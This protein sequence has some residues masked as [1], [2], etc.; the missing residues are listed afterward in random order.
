MITLFLVAGVFNKAS[1]GGVITPPAPDRSRLDQFEIRSA[2]RLRSWTEDVERFVA[3]TIEAERKD[4]RPKT[5]K[6][7]A[8]VVNDVIEAVGTGLLA[9]VRPT[10][11]IRQA[12]NVVLTDNSADRAAMYA[13]IAAA[14]QRQ[15]EEQDEEDVIALL[16][17]A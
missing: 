2:K 4:D 14:I 12:V 16:L 15:I 7:K 3:E 11:E 10:P 5:R 13:A 17:A 8:E 6:V 1:Q 9:T